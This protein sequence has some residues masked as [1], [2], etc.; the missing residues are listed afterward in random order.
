[1]DIRGSNICINGKNSFLVRLTWA[2]DFGELTVFDFENIKT[3]IGRITDDYCTETADILQ[4]DLTDYKL[5]ISQGLS[6]TATVDEKHRY[7][8]QLSDDILLLKKTECASQITYKIATVVLKNVPVNEILPDFMS[9][10]TSHLNQMSADINLKDKQ[11][12]ELSQ[13]LLNHAFYI[14]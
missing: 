4:M 7:H 12:Q 9:G 1:M 6:Q 13:G 11:I 2:G 14:V 8:I 5:E 10:L 3:S